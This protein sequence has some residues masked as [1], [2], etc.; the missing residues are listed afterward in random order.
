MFKQILFASTGSPP[1]DAAANV[2]FDMAQKYNAKLKVFHVYGFPSRG[3]SPFVVDV[4][5]GA[6]ED[7]H[8]DYSDWVM[9]ELRDELW[10]RFER[11]LL[12]LD[13]AGWLRTQ[14]LRLKRRC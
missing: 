3:Y 9:E 1:C 5:T 14:W 6:S 11:A 4:R 13:S 12:P 8:S 2:A 10:N 7:Q